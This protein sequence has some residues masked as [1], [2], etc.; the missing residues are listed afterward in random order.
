MKLSR[1]ADWNAPTNRLTIARQSRSDLLD[2]TNSNP[3]HQQ[4][5]ERDYAS[6]LSVFRKIFVSS[7]MG[8]RKP[9]AAAFAAISEEIG[10]PLERIL[11]FDDTKANVD[12]ALAVG[13]QEKSAVT[14]GMKRSNSRW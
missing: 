4:V 7:D 12:G 14:L 5:W 3:T 13:I 8:L 1:R 10:V 2:L 11:F 9:E 6:T